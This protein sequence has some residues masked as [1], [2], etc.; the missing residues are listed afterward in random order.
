M[1][2]LV[3]RTSIN[4]KSNRFLNGGKPRDSGKLSMYIPST[5]SEKH[6]F[7]R[8]TFRSPART[9]DIKRFC[10]RAWDLGSIPGYFAASAFASLTCSS[11]DVA[12]KLSLQAQSSQLLHEV[13]RLATFY[14]WLLPSL[15]GHVLLMTSHLLQGVVVDQLLVQG[16]Y[17]CLLVSKPKRA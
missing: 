8:W 1:L 9:V 10:R 7:L 4:L 15:K 13:R 14:A 5:M 2:F 3:D 12:C 16:F 6:R 11:S 17:D